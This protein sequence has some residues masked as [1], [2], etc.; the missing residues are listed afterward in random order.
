M[1]DGGS[2]R[3]DGRIVKMEVDY[4]ATVDQRLPECAK[5]AKASGGLRAGACIPPI[6]CSD[7]V[8]TARVG[9]LTSAQPGLRST[10]TPVASQTLPKTD[11]H[12]PLLDLGL[13]FTFGLFLDVV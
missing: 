8:G 13:R 12:F 11:D 4:S 1:A 5:L 3:A 6:T 10:P 9:D 7:L 2:E